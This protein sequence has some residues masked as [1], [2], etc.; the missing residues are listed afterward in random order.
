[1]AEQFESNRD[2]IANLQLITEGENTGKQD[3]SFGDWLDTRNEEYY[4]RHLIPREKRLHELENFLDF[5]DA[6]EQL[7]REHIRETFSEFA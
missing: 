4:E 3:D 7:I 5:L 1:V 6:R 2:S